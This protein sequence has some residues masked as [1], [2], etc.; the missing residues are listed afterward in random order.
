LKTLQVGMRSHLRVKSIHEK[1]LPIFFKMVYFVEVNAS[2][3]M[4]LNYANLV[5]SKTKVNESNYIKKKKLK[6]N[7]EDK[8]I[9]AIQVLP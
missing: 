6:P 8:V 1:T 7:L 4:G 9:L 3:K 5:I 2:H